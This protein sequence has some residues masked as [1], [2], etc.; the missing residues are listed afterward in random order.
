[1]IRKLVVVMTSLS[2][3]LSSTFLLMSNSEAKTTKKTATPIPSPS[4]KWPPVGFIGKDGVFATI[5]TNKELIGIL[6]AKTT[7][8]SDV[9][10]CKEYACGAVTVAAEK[11]CQWWEVRS[12]IYRADGE[13]K[14]AVGKL[15]TISKGT[16]AQE[17]K[18][19]L[20]VSREP[21]ADGITVGGIRVFCQRG[22][23]IVPYPSNSYE[24]ISN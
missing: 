5:P 24:P 15:F 2:V 22:A 3:F 12:V 16:N 17:I 13:N 8:A 18:T 9:K 6:S 19:I 4:P 20:M 7:L 10:L 11:S 21:L 1:M 23:T 14:V